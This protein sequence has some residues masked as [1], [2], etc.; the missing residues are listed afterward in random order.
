MRLFFLLLCVNSSL[1]VIIFIF[2]I[3]LL[4]FN[5]IYRAPRALKAMEFLTRAENIL[6][7]TRAYHTWVTCMAHY[8]SGETLISLEKSQ[9]YI[10]DVQQLLQ[11]ERWETIATNYGSTPNAII[12][13]F[14]IHC[15]VW[16]ARVFRF[17]DQKNETNIGEA[18]MEE[19][20]TILPKIEMCSEED[21]ILHLR[22]SYIYCQIKLLNLK[23]SENQPEI[24]QLFEEARNLGQHCGNSKKCMHFKAL[25]DVLYVTLSFRANRL[26]E[27]DL[28]AAEVEDLFFEDKTLKNDKAISLELA[29]LCI[30]QVEKAI[31][32]QK[33]ELHLKYTEQGLMFLKNVF[34]K[35]VTKMQC[36]L[37]QNLATMY[38]NSEQRGVIKCFPICGST[39]KSSKYIRKAQKG[40][41][42]LIKLSDTNLNQSK[43]FSHS[44]LR[45]YNEFES[46]SKSKNFQ[47]MKTLFAFMFEQIFASPEV[48]NLEIWEIWMRVLGN[49]GSFREIHDICQNSK[50]IVSLDKLVFPYNIIM[51]LLEKVSLMEISTNS[52]D[53]IMQ[54]R[55]KNV[56]TALTQMKVFSKH[57]KFSFWYSYGKKYY[58]EYL[59]QIRDFN[60]LYTFLQSN[61]YTSFRLSQGSLSSYA[62]TM[63]EILEVPMS[64]IAFE[65]VL[66][67]HF[68]RLN[69][70]RAVSNVF[71]SYTN[72]RDVLKRNFIVQEDHLRISEIQNC[73]QIVLRNM[74]ACVLMVIQI[75]GKDFSLVKFY[76]ALR[77][78][79]T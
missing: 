53:I 47:N 63:Q 69:Q 57:P 36:R 64:Q 71:Q 31:L 76:K 7:L 15:S 56:D 70:K 35:K 60:T 16:A 75:K 41:D 13:F 4:S 5:L 9:N 30:Y 50:Q 27:A 65:F 32:D 20:Q 44:M 67:A 46:T 24:E 42:N 78:M 29:H 3:R 48:D 68:E 43:W 54:Q 38:M 73:N 21:H 26:D 33:E 39:S 51:D 72:L 52:G 12:F 37:Y 22:L 40:W 2:L 1:L 11:H 45:N 79:S 17:D 61:P 66:S 55:L 49:A 74:A 58:L 23:M 14:T 25:I 19:A 34:G 62:T 18:V 8:A 77:D 10:K 28:R 6:N 59:T